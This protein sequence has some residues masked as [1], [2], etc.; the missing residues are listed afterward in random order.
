[1]G[2]RIP[3]DDERGDVL[4]MDSDGRL[5][6]EEC[7]VRMCLMRFNALATY[8]AS[9]IVDEYTLLP[10]ELT[11]K[12]G[13]REDF[14]R[15]EA[16]L[17]QAHP[18]AMALFKSQVVMDTT[19]TTTTATTES[20]SADLYNMGVALGKRV[21]QTRTVCAC[22]RC[23]MAMKREPAHA[24]AVYRCFSVTRNSQSPGLEGS[25]IA[26]TAAKK[27][28]QQ[29]ALYFTPIWS[30][31]QQHQGDSQPPPYV[32]AWTV[33]TDRQLLLDAALWRCIAHLQEWG[34]SPIGGGVRQ[35]L[36]AIFH[37]SHYVYLSSGSVQSRTMDLA[38]WHLRVWRPFYMQTYPANTFF[39]MRQAEVALLFDFSSQSGERWE[40][41]LR[42]RLSAVV[43][44][45]ETQPDGD[46]R[47]LAFMRIEEEMSSASIADERGM[48]RFLTRPDSRVGRKVALDAAW[49]FFRYCLSGGTST[50][51]LLH[52][53]DTLTLEMV[54]VLAATKQ[55][56]PRHLL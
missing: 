17:L 20:S 5:L 8:H 10:L 44:A 23:N 36:V 52:Q 43:D 30:R 7:A 42:G 26:A 16:A 45:L 11:G 24:T 49:A 13:F 33:K 18:Q 2:G 47:L 41:I 22:A 50:D 55:P 27:L 53:C 9:H 46:A 15:H 38:T 28:V 39:K 19:T 14:R 56:V 12:H 40:E 51:F 1:V 35:R 4:A 31:P 32:Q 25:Q 3:V 54:R 6:T 21:V 48:L 34:R 29:I 37:A